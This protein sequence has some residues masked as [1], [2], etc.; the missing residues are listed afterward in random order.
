MRKNPI[1]VSV[2]TVALFVL[3]V[4]TSSC[5]RLD[6]IRAF[7]QLAGDVG[8]RFPGL[9]RDLFGSCMS[10]QRF[11]VAQ[12][13]DFRVDRYGDLNEEGNSHMAENRKVCQPYNDEQDR[14]IKANGTLVSYMKSMGDLAADDLTNFDAS[15]EAFGSATT[16]ASLFKPEEA[17]AV[18]NLAKFL[19][20]I[21][22]E[23]YRRKQLRDVI[24]QT[25]PQIQTVTSA[26]HRIVLENYILQLQN[27]RLAMKEYY[28]ELATENVSFVKKLTEHIG[29]PDDIDPAPLD[30]I[31]TKLEVGNAAIN[32][33]INGAKAYAEILKTVAEGHQ[34]LYDNADK[35]SSR[36]VLTAALSYARTIQSLA[37]D[38]RNAF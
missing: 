10:Q 5:L 15:I 9:A 8:D 29:I 36:E 26:L 34:K 7:A 21:A 3:A 38:F 25:N 24:K 22:T 18:T 1:K 6:E 19:V 4:C 2:I 33:K 12:K 11:I 16:S 20:H 30:D 27:E 31:K 35:L 13:E 23:G 37:T 28:R 14:L 17:A 32:L